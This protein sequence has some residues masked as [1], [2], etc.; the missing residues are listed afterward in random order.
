MVDVIVYAV[1]VVDRRVEVLRRFGVLFGREETGEIVFGRRRCCL[2]G[3]PRWF[4]L[5]DVEAVGERGF[6]HCFLLRWFCGVCARLVGLDGVCGKL[7]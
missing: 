2:D 4:F 3:S 5:R 7:E 6:G 1:V